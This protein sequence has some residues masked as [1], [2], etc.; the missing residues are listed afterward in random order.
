[1]AEDARL[2]M[3]GTRIFPAIPGFFRLSVPGDDLVELRGVI[4]RRVLLDVKHPDARRALAEADLDEVAHLNVAGRLGGTAVHRDMIGVAGVVR[5]GAA[6]YQSGYL[7]KF[8]KPHK[9]TPFV[10]VV[11]TDDRLLVEG[12]LEGLAGGEAEVL[13]SRNSDRLTG[14]RV[15]AGALSSLLDLEG[16]E[17]DELNLL[18]SG[19]RALDG[20]ENGVYS[21]LCF[22]LLEAG[23][24]CD[25]VDDL[26]LVHF[27]IPFQLFVIRFYR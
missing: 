11:M 9:S 2:F 21:R 3:P 12:L 18:T 13:G 4:L 26:C 24:L 25:S 20:G 5:H 1:M 16:A 15:D 27:E 23:F 6:L 14:C 22:L 8:V 7:Q 17:A 10:L 19:E